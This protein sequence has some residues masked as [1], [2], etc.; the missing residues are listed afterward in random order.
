MSSTKVSEE[1]KDTIFYV[2]FLC[3]I[4]FQNP[5]WSKRQ[6]LD[7]KEGDIFLLIQILIHT[8]LYGYNSKVLYTQLHPIVPIVPIHL[9]VSNRRA[10]TC[11]SEIV[12]SYDW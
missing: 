7:F 11:F 8:H 5:K 2:L 3:Q 6:D 1:K 4:S 12:W 10:V 9:L